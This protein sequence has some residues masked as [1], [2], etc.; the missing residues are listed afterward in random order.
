MPTAGVRGIVR[1]V[2]ATFTLLDQPDGD[3][4]FVPNSKVMGTAMVN[5]SADGTSA[6]T[7]NICDDLMVL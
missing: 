1:E 6:P 7:P 4:C 2:R 3:L 5:H